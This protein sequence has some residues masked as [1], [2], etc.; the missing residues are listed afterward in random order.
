MLWFNRNRPLPGDLIHRCPECGS[1]HYYASNIVRTS[2]TRNE[3]LLRFDT[4]DRSTC[5]KCG[6]IYVTT[7]EGV[8]RPPAPRQS[9]EVEAAVKRLTKPLSDVPK[10]RPTW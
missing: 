3:R 1:R 9:D 7:D 4:G 10:E 2:V 6:C 5:A 8:F